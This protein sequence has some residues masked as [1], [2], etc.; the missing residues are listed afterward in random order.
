MLGALSSKAVLRNGLSLLQIVTRV[1]SIAADPTSN[2][3]EAAPA[4]KRK[5]K[6][7]Q[8]DEGKK[9]QR[10]GVAKGSSTQAGLPL[11]C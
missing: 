10:T 1:A 2:E 8:H 7:D 4:I 6:A 5:K 9:R 3:P 11:V